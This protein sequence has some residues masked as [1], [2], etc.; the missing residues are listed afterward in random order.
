VRVLD[1]SRPLA[2]VLAAALAG[3]GSAAVRAPIVADSSMF[4]EV[5]HVGLLFAEGVTAAPDGSVYVSDITTG[6]GPNDPGGIIYRYDPVT[7]SI[8]KYLEPSGVSNGLHVDAS[9]NNLLIAQTGA[10]AIARRNLSSGAMTTLASGYDGKQ[11]LAPND[12]TSDAHGH[13]YFTDAIYQP[14]QGAVELPNAFYRI[15]P[16]G[17]VV[18]LSTDLLRPNGIEVSPDGRRL[19]VAAFNAAA[20]PQ[21]PNGPAADRFGLTFGGVVVYDLDAS[22]NISNGRVFYRNDGL[23]VDGMAMDTDGDLYLALHNGNFAQPKGEIVVLDSQGTQL[24]EIPLPPHV[25]PTN[26][27]FGRGR[28]AHTLYMTSP[29]PWRLFKITTT[30]VGFS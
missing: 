21:N 24:T 17:R 11:L 13:V 14:V 16:D 4:V 30:R 20:L 18:Q 12:I 29:V 19:Y 2:V 15:D 23:G 3:C 9:G 5:S 22:G 27:G 1:C 8:A 7:D 26:L 10:R 6:L 25:A 28:D